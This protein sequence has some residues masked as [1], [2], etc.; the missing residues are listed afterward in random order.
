MNQVWTMESANLYC[1]S[2][3]DDSGA[4]NHLVL[5]ELKLPALDTQYTS[6]RAGGAPVEIEIDTVM[7]RLE[8]TFSLVGITPQVMNLLGAWM[9]PFRKNTFY[10]YGVVRNQVSGIPAQAKA[11]MVGQLGR[12]DMQNFRRG[13]VLH[14]AYAIRG[15]IQYELIVA[16]Q[17]VFYWDWATNTRV[18]GDQNL[19]ADTN[20]LLLIDSS[21]VVAPG[22]G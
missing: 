20:S 7:A 15:I 13:D 9:A 11:T 6:H 14:T 4:S 3:P 8:C 21:T 22:P 18:V 17:N 2:A 10:A 5:T 19:N 16:D 1:G 12:V